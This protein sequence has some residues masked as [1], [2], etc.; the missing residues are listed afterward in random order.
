MIEQIHQSLGLTAR[1]HKQALIQQGLLG[2]HA[3]AVEDEVGQLLVG[4]L[5]SAAQHHL[6]FGGGS[7]HR[8]P[9]LRVVWGFQAAARTLREV[10]PRLLRVTSPPMWS[11]TTGKL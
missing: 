3:G 7:Q 10:I 2:G 5:T 1:H 9:E 6:L 8:R 11:I 4:D